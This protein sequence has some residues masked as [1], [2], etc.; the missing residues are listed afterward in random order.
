MVGE[1]RGPAAKLVEIRG[2]ALAGEGHVR[3]QQAQQHRGPEDCQEGP[4]VGKAADWGTRGN[5]WS[6]GHGIRSRFG[7]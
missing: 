2:V 4:V 1:D 6:F 7:K 3:Q 5:V